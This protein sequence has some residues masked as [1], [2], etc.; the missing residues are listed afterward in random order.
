MKKI[1]I[2]DDDG[3]ILEA[4]SLILI[5]HGYA[6]ETTTDGKKIKKI[7]RNFPDLILLDIWMPRDHGG[8]ICRD[9]KSR[10]ATKNIPIILFSANKDTR[11]IA[12]QS[13]ADD[14]LEKPFDID[15]LLKKVRLHTK[16]MQ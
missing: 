14:Y 7:R 11:Q 15:Y 1:L 13:G 12:R 3:A 2:V 10:K 9:L 5:E 4:M 8:T 6:V 16:E